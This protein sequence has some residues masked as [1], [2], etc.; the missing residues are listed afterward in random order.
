MSSR[1]SFKA[2]TERLQRILERAGCSSIVAA[3]LASNCA[4]AERDGARSHG[5]FRMQGYVSSLRG[6]WV[7]GH[8][9]PRV[10]DVAAGF[11]RVD[12]KNGYAVP[13]LAAA[14]ELAINKARHNGVAVIAIRNSHHL[15]ALALDVEPFAERGLVA[16]AIVNSMKSVV[17]HGGRLPVFGTNPIAFASP[18]AS[19][20]PFVFDQA[21]SAMAHGD[22]KIAMREGR[23]LPPGI[24]VDRHGEPTSDPAE[25]VGGGALRTFGGHKGA[26]IAIMV[27]VLCAALAGGQFSF[28]CDLAAMPGASTPRTGQTL[29][30]IDPRTG[31]AGLADFAT[32]VDE[33]LA[34]V[35]AAG[36][37][38]LPGERR[39]A[40]RE[41][42]LRDG[43]EL[44]VDELASL[45]LLEAQFEA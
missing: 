17:P 26:S 31:S 10:E 38:R 23:T 5:I 16:I 40:I 9:V 28:E 11:V 24:G 29:L 1:V 6:N 34:Q 18:R 4:G 35:L 12:A 7:D 14:S 36:Q 13:A 19:G 39:L 45:D 32:R 15:G 3:Q 20:A 21:S 2:L 33:L 44:S 27:E 37:S 30:L 8:A 41:Q 42:S 25:I 22:V 43:I